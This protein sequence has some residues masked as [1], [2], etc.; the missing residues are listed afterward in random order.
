M[1][2]NIDFEALM[3][4]LDEIVKKMESKVLPLQESINL[5]EEGSKIINKLET[6]LS[7]AEKKIES[8]ITINKS[9]SDI[10]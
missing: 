9:N 6:A 8:L 7:A 4:R 5:F 10:K 1:E 3:T 2:T